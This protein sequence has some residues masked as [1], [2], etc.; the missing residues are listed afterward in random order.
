MKKVIIGAVLLLVL[1]PLAL[2]ENP[3]KYQIFSE[4]KGW[5]GLSGKT[6]LML[7]KETGDSWVLEEGKWIAVPKVNNEKLAEE[8]SKAQ[9]AEQIRDLQDRY[10]QEINALKAKQAEEIKAL[11]TKQNAPKDLSKAE[12]RP[13]ANHWKRFNARKVV[14]PEKTTASDAQGEEGP[15]AWLSE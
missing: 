6:T 14:R 11:M 2:A 9:L 12:V 10:E 5:F 8:A 15:P 4:R 7:D 3:N 1:A 13:A